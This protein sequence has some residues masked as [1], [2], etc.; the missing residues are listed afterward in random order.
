MKIFQFQKRSLIYSLYHTNKLVQDDLS[1]RL[2]S[3]N[4]TFPQSLVL[5]T[6]FFEGQ[7]K[8]TP[9]DLEYSLHLS[10]SA[11]SQILSQ[12]EAK[13]FVKRVIKENDARS[14]M[15]QLTAQGKKISTKMISDFDVVEN[16]I[17][18]KIKGKMEGSN[19]KKFLTTFQNI[20]ENWFNH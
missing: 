5:A 3:H 17:E 2:Q 6:L 13:K 20:I 18:K 12:L 14:F 8:L 10:K 15:I 7:D 16:K 4:L 1:K 11:L 19:N 9:K